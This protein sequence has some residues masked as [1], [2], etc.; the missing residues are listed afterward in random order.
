MNRKE[1][2]GDYYYAGGKKVRLQ[3]ASP[4]DL[5]RAEVAQPAVA[6]SE[7]ANRVY[8]VGDTIVVVMPE[9]RV[10]ESRPQHLEKLEAWLAE[11]KASVEVVSQ[12]DER[13][14]LRPL[15]MRGSDALDIANA[16]HEEI[17]REMAQARFICSTGKPM[18]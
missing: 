7:A 16:L 3:A 6:Q 13:L 5:V 17:E 12:T 10:E 18:T 15:S 11:H 2:G 1:R 14:V 4:S 9:V 8:R